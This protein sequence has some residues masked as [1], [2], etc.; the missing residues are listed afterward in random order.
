MDIYRE[1]KLKNEP[2]KINVY[3]QF[4][5]Q[6]SSTQS[7]LLI[8]FNSKKGRMHM[9]FLQA[10]VPPSKGEVYYKKATLE[11]DIKDVHL[12]DH[13]EMHKQTGKMMFSSTTN[14]AMTLSRLQDTFST[15]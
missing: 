15:I 5:K 1:I 14:T 8:T 10:Q 11:F 3:N 12:I 7:R 9:D 13:M 4:W 2:L 6:I